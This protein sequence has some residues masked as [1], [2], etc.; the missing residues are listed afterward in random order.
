[1]LTHPK[2][3]HP[4]LTVSV[5]LIGADVQYSRIQVMHTGVRGGAY[6]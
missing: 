6:E 1:M 3:T 4:G 2:K 5:M